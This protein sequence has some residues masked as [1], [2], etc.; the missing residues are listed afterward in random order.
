MGAQEAAARVSGQRR[1]DSPGGLTGGFQVS[2]DRLQ[3][4][5]K[6]L[7]LSFGDDGKRKPVHGPSHRLG[8]L[9]QPLTF[10]VPKASWPWCRPDFADAAR[11]LF[12][13]A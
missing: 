10:V 9:Q 4:S 6:G 2:D 5:Q 12:E 7:A 11:A 1:E 3:R 8:D 13:Q